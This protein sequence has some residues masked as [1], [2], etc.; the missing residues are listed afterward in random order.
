MEHISSELLEA[1]KEAAIEAGEAV[2]EVYNSDFDVSYKEDDSPLTEADRRSH[3][4]IEKKISELTPNIPL[5]SEEG[6]SV[7]WPIRKEWDLFYLVDPLDGTKE[8]VKRNGDFTVN[9]ALIRGDRPVL[10]V[11]HVPVKGVT[12]WA[13]EG[14]GAYRCE[15]GGAPEKIAAKNS[16]N[17]DGIVAVASRS[18]GAEATEAFLDNFKVKERVS[19]GSSL[20]F[21]LVA[22]GTAHLYPRFGPT[23]EWDTA[24]GHCVVNEAG[25]TVTDL[26]GEILLYNKESLLNKGFIAAGAFALTVP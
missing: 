12:Y 21:C 7:A 18:H 16:I 20:K 15:A 24:A 2:L 19:R 23:W 8:F 6:S 1:L 11:V 3:V 22:E 13:S 25:G 17:D 26:E 10:G 5:L 14:R 4:I 9:I